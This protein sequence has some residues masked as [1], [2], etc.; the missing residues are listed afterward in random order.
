MKRIMLMLIVLALV[1]CGFV[2]PKEY[3]MAIE[4]CKSNGGVYT[5]S[6]SVFSGATVRCQNGIKISFE[7]PG[8]NYK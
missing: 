4:L 7:I 1:G 2:N 5:V 6:P 3:E 8:K